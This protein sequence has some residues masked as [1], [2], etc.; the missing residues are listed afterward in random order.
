VSSSLQNSLQQLCSDLIAIE[1]PLNV[2]VTG[3]AVD[4]RQVKPGDLFFAFKGQQVDSRQYCNDAL[5]KGA[6]AVI[7]EGEPS[8]TF[9]QGKP[10][11]TIADI[12]PKM[13]KIAAR[14]YDDPTQD[15]SVI[16]IT[17]TNGK[18]SCSQWLAQALSQCGISCGVIGTLGWGL[19]SELHPLENTTPGPI[20]L[21][22]IAHTLLQQGTHALAMEVSSHALVQHRV[23]AVKFDTA[24]FTNL[25]RDHLDYHQDMAT[26]A[27]AKW[28]LFLKPELRYAIINIDD[29]YGLQYLTQLPS[30]VQGFG[31][32][33]SN[34]LAIK[35][36]CVRAN[37]MTQDSRGFKIHF[38]TPWGEGL[39]QTNLMGRF[40]VS[41][42]CAVLTSLGVQ[43]I[44]L[45][46]ALTALAEL[47]SVPG[48]MECLG[49]NG[50]PRVVI[51]FAHTP[52]A[53]A[54][55][56]K[57]LRKH[58]SAKLWC[59][60]GCGGDRDKGKRP[61]MGQIAEQ[62]ADSVVLTQDNS[63]S[64]DPLTIISH[65][66]Q[67]MQDVTA[68]VELDRAAAIHFAIAAAQVNDLIL[69]AGKGHENYQEIAGKRHP[70]SDTLQA[71]LGLAKRV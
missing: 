37:I 5:S 24:V 33:L 51:D 65:I 1:L 52:D 10:I 55:V 25:T 59:V 30:Q 2:K 57:A 8:L 27:A 23:D 6:V 63:R 68:R 44:P 45:N 29:P 13:A 11:I 46:Q 69:I 42:L 36:P 61:L 54:Q 15:L 66:R 60:F 3:I 50:L 49:G 56:L 39:L 48:R 21:Q 47:N 9:E 38:V 18:T 22:E 31:Y 41:N 20:L 4:S 62:L 67:G 71:K 32:S 34:D 26:Y 7:S 19:P 28:Q 70:F 40:N 12:M 64:E 14:F 43:G 17:G 35:Q 53:L 58:C 16:G